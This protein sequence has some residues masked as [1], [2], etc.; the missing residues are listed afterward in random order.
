MSDQ[1]L[2]NWETVVLYLA[3]A[4]AALFPV[5]AVPFPPLADLP[6]HLARAH[7]MAELP[8][9]PALQQHYALAWQLLSFQVGDLVLPPLVK[10]FG[11]EPAARIFVA[12]S[13]ATLLA[14]VVALHRVLFGRV[15]AWPLLA[16]LLLYNF[17]LGWGLLSYLFSAGLA[18]ILLAAWI[19]T[20]PREG[21]MRSAAFAGAALVLFCCHFLAFAV[22]ALTVLAF[23]LRRWR[24]DRARLL[25]RLV[26]SGAIFVVPALLFLLAPRAAVPMVNDYGDGNDKV[27]AVLAP[28]NLYFGW[29]DLLLAFLAFLLAVIGIWRRRFPV[30]VALRWPVIAVGVAALLMPSQL[31]SVWGSDFRLPTVFLLMLIA[32]TDLP[33]QRRGAAAVFVAAV[34]ALMLV[35]VATVTADWRRLDADIGEFRA[36]L[37]V[38]DRGSR[39]VVAQSLDDDRVPPVPSLYPYRHFA[40]FAVIDRDVFLPHLFSAATPLRFV[41]PGGRWN[42]DQLAVIRNPKWHPADPAFAATDMRSQLQARAVTRAIQEFDLGTSSIDWTDWPERFDF[43]IAIDYGQA[44]N[45]V[46]ALL[47]ELHRGSFFTI[48]RIHPPAP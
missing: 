37:G 2:R 19:Q 44:E 15:G 17:M 41:S 22:F 48:Y 27:R 6:N 20:A 3:L 5:F 10:W 7:I 9:D 25:R 31:M 34:A 14:G 32:A 24:D 21:P 8:G 29:Q 16:F 38:I 12:A 18:L 35:R 13:F 40:A 47:T 28:F 36:A 26:L 23:E 39:V 43:L 30:A 4:A 11:V 1:P 42:T 46:P 45:P 33:W